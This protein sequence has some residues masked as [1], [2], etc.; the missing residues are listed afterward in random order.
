MR[1]TTETDL[2]KI[3]AVHK[4]VEKAAARVHPTLLYEDAV[5]EA[6]LWLS[7]APGRNR[8][9][10]ALLPDGTIYIKQ[11]AADIFNSRL[12]TRYERELRWRRSTTPFRDEVG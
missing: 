12:R 4:A 8:V 6:W 7:T 9:R 5:Q 3:P 11:L 2:W 1:I 10:H